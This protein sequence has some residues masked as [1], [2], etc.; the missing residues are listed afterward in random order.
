MVNTYLKYI[1]KAE[2]ENKI[3]CLLSTKNTSDKIFTNE[4]NT[5][6]SIYSPI[7]T[8]KTKSKETNTEFIV[9]GFGIR[10]TQFTDYLSKIKIPFSTISVDEAKSFYAM[11]NLFTNGIET[12]TKM[13]NNALSD[14]KVDLSHLTKQLISALTESETDQG[15][16]YTY[17]THSI[18]KTLDLLKSKA[19][20]APLSLYKILALNAIE[21]TDYTKREN[22]HIKNIILDTKNDV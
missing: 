5:H 20:P 11:I 13:M 18:I 4:L 17:D 19:S 21:Y 2:V 1:H 6:L 8:G 15:T 9:E 12:L 16:F 3:I 7:L 10:Y 22:E 14:S